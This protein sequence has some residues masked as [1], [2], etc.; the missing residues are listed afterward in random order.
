MY[1]VNSETLEKGYVQCN[2]YI[3]NLNFLEAQIYFADLNIFVS[4][5]QILLKTA[6]VT[7]TSSGSLFSC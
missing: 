1:E 2:F 3:T 5:N 6:L 4:L 7:Q